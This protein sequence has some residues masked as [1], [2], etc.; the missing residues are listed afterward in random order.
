MKTI[1]VISD[2]HGLVRPEATAALRGCDALVHAG[3]IG[4][5]EV[6]EQLR[7][8]GPV[9][10][11]RGNVDA[12]AGDL[13]D[14]ATLTLDGVRVY[15]IHDV[16]ELDLDPREAG[17]GA[18]IC[19]HSHVPKVETK[20]GV[21]YLNPGSAG[22]RRFKLPIGVAKLRIAADGLAAELITLTPR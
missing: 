11:I 6:L 20:D 7:E 2:T 9:T 21:L 18:V 3:D 14:T 5:P 16:R 17:L 10:A 4:K 12:W 15:V 8:L 13:P 1:G 22:P 19:G